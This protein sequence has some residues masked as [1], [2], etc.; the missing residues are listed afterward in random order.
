MRQPVTIEEVEQ[1]LR[2]LCEHL[3]EAARMQPDPTM[4][5]VSFRDR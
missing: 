4:Q 5:E 3:E 2:M 1:T